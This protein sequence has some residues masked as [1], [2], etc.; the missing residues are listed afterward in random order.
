M[1][2]RKKAGG[3][4]TVAGKARSA[5]NSLKHG[6]AQAALGSP[7]Q[8]AVADY[9]LELTNYYDPQSPLEKLQIERIAI[10]RAKLARLYQVEQVRLELVRKELSSS[11]DLVFRRLGVLSG[12]VKSMTLEY[13]QEGK[14]H[15]PFG[16]VPKQLAAID[17]E[18]KANTVSIESEAQL[19]KQLP[20][21]CVFLK[22]YQPLEADPS[23]TLLSKLQL[24]SLQLNRELSTLN[25]FLGKWRDIIENYLWAKEQVVRQ[26]T[27]EDEIEMKELMRFVSSSYP[28]K[29]ERRTRKNAANDA[30]NDFSLLPNYLKVF[31]ELQNYCKAAE[32]L[33]ERFIVAKN[34][35]ANSVM[36]PVQESD[37]LLRYQ[38][39]LERRLSA[40]I[41]E[42]LE[43]Q[44]RQ[45]V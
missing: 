31:G 26:K 4:V 20:S 34:L 29:E 23:A 18:I 30:D 8:A 39:T 25:T 21:L 5:Q 33:V 3:P 37:L 12:V 40:T 6:I 44:K 42:L 11:P 10:Y 2:T 19:Q 7:E 36:L 45:A 43:I 13:I 41:G 14:L 1:A 22:S 15:L 28:M 9:I 27:K 32:H 35:M 24:V 38:T 16:L 17:A